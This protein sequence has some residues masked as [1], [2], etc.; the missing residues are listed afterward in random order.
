EQALHGVFGRRVQI[1]GPFAES[2]RVRR[3]GLE[4]EIADAGCRQGRRLDLE[5]AARREE[6][7]D[8]GE[9]AGAAAQ[10]LEVG[11]GR[12]AHAPSESSRPTLSPI[13]T[14]TP[15]VSRASQ[16]A[17]RG[18]STTTTVDPRLKRPSSAPRSSAMGGVSRQS[19]R[20]PLATSPQLTSVTLDTF[21]APTSTTA[22][23]PK[24]V[25]KRQTTR[26]LRVKRFGIAAAVRP[27][28]AK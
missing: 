13:A 3:H 19:R 23:G 17:M 15:G 5:H 14:L 25:S 24:R 12:E 21:S 11:A 10:V 8:R 26:S 20:A 9:D 7:P 16:R 28:T 22:I 27:L 1:Q 18:A 6:P 4:V 2:V